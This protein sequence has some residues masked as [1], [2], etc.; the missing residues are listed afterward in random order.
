MTTNH[1]IDAYTI[2]AQCTDAFAALER[3]ATTVRTLSKQ[4]NADFEVVR[5]AMSEVFLVSTRVRAVLQELLAIGQAHARLFYASPKD[6]VSALYSS[7]PWGNTTPPAVMITGLAGVGKSAVVLAAQRFLSERGGPVDLPGHKNLTHTPVWLM[8]VR[9]A[10]TLNGL[11]RPHIDASMSALTSTKPLQQSK[12]VELA[13]RVSRRDGTCISLI[14]ELQFRTHSSNAN[15]QV[16]GL[17]LNLL[18]LGPRLCYVANFSLAHRLKER[19]HEDRQR[20]L[21]HPIVLEPESMD[22]ACFVRLLEEYLNVVPDD[23]S[24]APRQMIEEVHRYTFGIKRSVVNLLSLSWLAAKTKRGWKAK[25]T[26]DDLR[27]AFLSQRFMAFREDA[28]LLSRFAVGDRRIREDLINPFASAAPSSSSD[29]IPARNAIDE[30]R[31]QVLQSHL[32]DQM[33]P[34]EKAALEALKQPIANTLKRS[35]VVRLRAA[36]PTKSEMLDALDRL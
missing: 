17:L 27:S 25:V 15:T 16:T 34:A 28:E 9:D 33:T 22:S 23:F 11:V 2:P 6:I 19:R 24:L 35:H 12:L 13:R 36:A 5:A 21:S 1:W 26:S 10:G 29:V 30:Y 7:M 4:P 18:S 3:R 31:R 32:D 14:D 20:L 8:S